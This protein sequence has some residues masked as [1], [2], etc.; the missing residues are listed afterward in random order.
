M[1]VI[2]QVMCSLIVFSCNAPRHGPVDN[3]SIG[4]DEQVIETLNHVFDNTF[5]E[6]KYKEI[7]DEDYQA[8]VV[9]QLQLSVMHKFWMC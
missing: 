8:T 4:I 1:T 3:V 9:L 7:L 2:L 5:W 6:E